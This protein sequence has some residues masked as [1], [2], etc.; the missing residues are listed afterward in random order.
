[1]NLPPE[2]NDITIDDE[3]DQ[4]FA[5]FEDQ[6]R[7]A[8]QRVRNQG[9]RPGPTPSLAFHAGAFLPA[10]PASDLPPIF[11][12]GPLNLNMD[13]TEINYRKS[14]AG[15][16]ADYWRRADG[17]EIERLLTTGTIKHILFSDIPTN[18]VVTYVNPICVEKTN[19][20]GSLKFRT[21]LTRRGSNCLPL[22]HNCRD[23]GD[24]CIKDSS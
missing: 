20:D 11:P 24:E 16:N 19:D 21:R 18:R 17:E 10:M 12:T 22:R 8:E 7:Q 23:G 5:W 4:F 3:T 9:P 2:G 13:G 14:H 15:P 1:M 6:E